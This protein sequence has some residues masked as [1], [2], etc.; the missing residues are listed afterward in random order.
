[1]NIE[2]PSIFDAYKIGFSCQIRT[3]NRLVNAE[4]AKEHDNG[5]VNAM[6]V[7]ETGKVAQAYH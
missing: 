6:M 4:D 3:E 1:M 2:R 5:M 7:G